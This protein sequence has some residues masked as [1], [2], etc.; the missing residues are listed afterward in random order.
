MSKKVS[1]LEGSELDYWAVKAANPKRVELRGKKPWVVDDDPRDGIDL[2]YKPSS[3]W[4]DGGPLIEE[5]Q[6]A[7]GPLMGGAG[8][9]A[10]VW[11]DRLEDPGPIQQG[12]T[13]LTAACRAIVASVYGEEAPDD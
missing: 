7:L 2:P 8:F 3:F 6:V 4:Q 9:E 1:E 13:A 12:E 10:Q 11:K 5:W